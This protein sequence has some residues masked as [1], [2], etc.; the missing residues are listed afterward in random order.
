MT[1][2]EEKG[3][4]FWG[5]VAVL[6]LTIILLPIAIL[7]YYFAGGKKAMEEHERKQKDAQNE[8]RQRLIAKGIVK[9]HKWDDNPAKVSGDQK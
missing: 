5:V 8:A 1:K 3:L 2:F 7:I 9:E 6:G 4:F